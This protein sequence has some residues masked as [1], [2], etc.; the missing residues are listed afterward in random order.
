MQVD[1]RVATKASL[2]PSDAAAIDV[3]EDPCPWV[4][5]AGL[6]LSH[7]LEVFDLSPVGATVLDLGCGFGATLAPTAGRPRARY[8]GVSNASFPLAVGRGLLPEMPEGYGIALQLADLNDPRAL[9][10][11]DAILALES[12]AYADCLSAAAANIVA[13]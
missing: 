3:A 8:V 6:K 4:S 9:G 12:L 1:G 2:T 11:F 10:R 13:A 7:A 5:R